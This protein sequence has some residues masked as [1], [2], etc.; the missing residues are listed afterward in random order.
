MSPPERRSRARSRRPSFV[1]AG[2]SAASANTMAHMAPTASTHDLIGWRMQALGLWGR[3]TVPAP[4]GTPSAAQRVRAVAEHLLAAQGQDWN[5]V[6]WALGVRASAITDADVREAFQSGSLVRSWPMRGTVHVVPAEDIGWMQRATNHRVLPGAA[7]R[8]AFLG[9]DD[10]SLALMT[11]V[12]V[13]RLGGGRSAN[14]D[15][16][17]SAWAQAGVTGPDGDGLGPWRYHVIWWLSQNGIIVSG[18]LDDGGAG[19]PRFVLTDEWIASPRSLEGEEALV[20]LVTRFVRG[21]GPVLERDFSWWTGLTMREAKTAFVG[22]AAAGA[23]TVVDVNG[24]RYYAEPEL[25]AKAS[26]VPDD[27]PLLLLPAFDEHLLGYTDRSAVLDPAQFTRIVPGRNGIFRSTV[28]DEGRVVGVWNRTPRSSH[29][30]LTI[31]PFLGASIDPLRLQQAAQAW[32]AFAGTE[33]E[34]EIR[35]G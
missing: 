3:I 33:V 12:T 32:G 7:K 11:E 10:A 23:I 13:S 28:V 31:E 17:A 9:L 16:L 30:R 18:P 24:Q 1:G 35:A 25:V 29:T 26:A 15:E 4:G 6:R 19:E 27:A 22:A 14:R 20:E 8:R 5:A 2:H 21:R 34:A